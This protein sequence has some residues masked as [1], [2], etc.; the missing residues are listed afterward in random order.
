MNGTWKILEGRR[1]GMQRHQNRRGHVLQVSEKERELGVRVKCF[2]EWELKDAQ[3]S[4]SEWFAKRKNLSILKEKT[5]VIHGRGVVV[6]KWK[7]SKVYVSFI[8]TRKL[9]EYKSYKRALHERKVR[10]AQ[11]SDSTSK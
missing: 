6:G 10:K 4:K 11:K 2:E 7:S 8:P 1:V 9:E 3:S 5:K